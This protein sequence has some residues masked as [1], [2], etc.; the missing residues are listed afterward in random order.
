M[1]ISKVSEMEASVA[2]ADLQHVLD[3][4]V[5]LRQFSQQVAG[6]L[7][8]A[9]TS[10]IADYIGQSA[11]IV[12]LHGQLTSCD[13]LLARM[14]G[15]L[16]S[17]SFNLRS[18]GA[19]ID[20]LQQ[21]SVLMNQKLKNQQA[22]RCRLTQLID[23]LTLPKTMVDHICNT[24]VTDPVFAEQL[25]LLDSKLAVLRAYTGRGGGA[26]RVAACAD[27]QPVLERLEARAVSR[28]R[29]FLMDKVYQLRR[30]L[31]NFHVPQD[32]LLAQRHLAAF[33]A[34]HAAD[35]AA[36]QLR[37]EYVDTMSK[38]YCSYLGAYWSR[39]L[40]LLATETAPTRHDLLAA[41]D[42]SL[43]SSSSLFSA[44]RTRG[45]CVFSLGQRASV[46]QQVEEPAIV[47][48]VASANSC[49]VEQLFRSGYYVL[50]DNACREF[51]FLGQFFSADA[52]SAGRRCTEQLFSAVLG[53][54]LQLVNR[55]CD[56]LLAGCHDL[57][58][59][60]LCIHLVQRMQLLCHR[61]A[62]PALDTHWNR[63]LQM[64]W[65]LFERLC[66]AN[67][68]SVRD[69]VVERLPAIDTRP[70]VITRRYAQLAAAVLTV[71]EPMPTERVHRLLMR[72]R[73]EVEALLLRMAGQLPA[74]G[75]QLVLLINNYDLV[76]GAL[77][78]HSSSH[79]AGNEVETFSRLLALRSADY[80][81]LALTPHF[82]GLVQLVKDA[83]QLVERGDAQALSEQ[84]MLTRAIR[85]IASF[86]DTWRQA[87]QTLNSQLMQAFTNFRNGSAILQEALK[88]LVIYCDR[89]HRLLAL[90]Q[91]RSV[92]NRS[93][94]VNTHTVMVEVKKYKPN[95]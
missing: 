45:R 86:N 69:C 38:V 26:P 49:S 30:P 16:D 75:D 14:E 57:L 73:V 27:V 66:E 74:R 1:N 13:E 55:H 92:P 33:L 85:V 89:F 6:S 64:L 34:A 76:L 5:D 48:H 42:P 82:G 63:Q 60:F 43:S 29:G 44:P 21:Q 39:L 12:Q 71:N 65:P 58:G 93:T 94:M 68:N 81:Q 56:Q 24:P 87:L 15:Q 7:R 62:V 54:S 22:V 19:E 28:V 91:M 53:R 41:D 46:L 9:E 88:Q 23:E 10:S 83:E 72:M 95:F 3:S 17:F 37:A 70:H 36:A 90:P 84:H 35:T 59:V 50:M 20:Q 4:G 25:S 61:R 31:A 52:D 11:N 2:P 80:V 77:H 78:D 18:I 40:P 47:P 67:V 79:S 32:L 51:L 8:A